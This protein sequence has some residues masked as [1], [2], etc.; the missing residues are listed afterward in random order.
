MPSVME[1]PYVYLATDGK[2]SKIG[3]SHNPW[4]RL[5]ALYS[6]RRTKKR[7]KISLVST[8]LVGRGSAFNVETLVKAE[9]EEFAVSGSEWFSI[10]C[11]EIIRFVET[12]RPKHLRLIDGV[13]VEQSR[14]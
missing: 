13:W 6:P 8:W 14:E 9:Y 3:V 2:Y 11:P 12:V 10:S 4:Q 5:K 7:P 1:C